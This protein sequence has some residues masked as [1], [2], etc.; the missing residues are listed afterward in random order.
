MLG[1]EPASTGGNDAESWI[2]GDYLGQVGRHVDTNVGRRDAPN[3]RPKLGKL[4]GKTRDRM[5]LRLSELMPGGEAQL[6]QA[7]RALGRGPK[8]ARQSEPRARLSDAL[9]RLFEQG[10]PVG[11][12]PKDA[13]SRKR[14]VPSMAALMDVLGCDRGTIRSLRD[15]GNSGYQSDWK[16]QKPVYIHPAKPVYANAPQTFHIG[17]KVMTPVEELMISKLDRIAEQQA[18]LE[19]QMIALSKRTPDDDVFV[20]EIDLLLASVGDEIAQKD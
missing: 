5:R 18:S 7:I 10:K 15:L 4:N 17:E 11:D 9:A 6:D 2:N 16:W 1:S 12:R 20:R 19:M 8:T 3:G 14:V 13:P